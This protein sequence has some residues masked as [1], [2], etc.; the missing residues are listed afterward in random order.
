MNRDRPCTVFGDVQPCPLRRVVA[1]LLEGGPEGLRHRHTG[2]E[3]I[4]RDDRQVHHRT[5]EE[6]ESG[7]I[8]TADRERPSARAAVE[9]GGTEHDLA[10]MARV[11]GMFCGVLCGQQLVRPL[12]HRGG[13]KSA[14]CQGERAEGEAKLELVQFEAESLEFDPAGS[15]EEGEQFGPEG[16]DQVPAVHGP[17]PVGPGSSR[18]MI[19]RSA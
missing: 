19:T 1:D 13:G 11:G 9:P 8:G 16:P 3:D 17:L 2:V 7:G 15:T 18:R 14:V 12:W 10:D 4:H 5:V 6:R